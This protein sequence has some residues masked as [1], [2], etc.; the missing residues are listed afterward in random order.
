MERFLYKTKSVCPVCLREIYADI[1][2]KEDGIYMDKV[3]PEHG[4]V[5][6]L[7]WADTGDGYMKWLSYGG[8]STDELPQTEQ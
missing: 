5:S 1:L 2:E 7:I 8:I 3:C 4:K 6:T